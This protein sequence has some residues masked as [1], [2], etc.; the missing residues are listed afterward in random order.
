[1]IILM[2]YPVKVI[3]NG[4]NALYYAVSDGNYDC[5]KLF[6]QAGADINVQSHVR[7]LVN[8]YTVCCIF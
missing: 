2:I 7:A 8:A 1:M 3:Q 4:Y 6:I 5:A